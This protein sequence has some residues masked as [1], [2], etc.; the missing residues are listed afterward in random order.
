MMI[1]GYAR[2]STIDQTFGLESQ[3]EQLANI[4]CERIFQEKASSRGK[5]TELETVINFVREGDTL[6][7]TKL[8]RLARSVR[9]LYSIVERLSSKKVSLRIMNLGLDTAT[10]TGKLMLTMLSAV[11]E[12]ER[13]IMLERQ[14]DGINKARQAGKRF[15]RNPTARNKADEILRL[16]DT[17]LGASQIAKAV[18]VS[19]ASVYRVTKDIQVE[20]EAA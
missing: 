2:T 15:G 5:R 20:T 9:D 7:V 10:A 14:R 8:D 19:R 17:G 6:I 4:G 3:I 1:V 18:G 13:D 12:F 11:A 16:K